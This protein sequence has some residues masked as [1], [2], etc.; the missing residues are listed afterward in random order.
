MTAVTK[1][2]NDTLVEGLLHERSGISD[3]EIDQLVLGELTAVERADVERRGATDP[4]FAGRVA[5]TR[6]AF[7]EDATVSGVPIL[8]NILDAVARDG[9]DP[10]ASEALR[11]GLVTQA[12]RATA[13]PARR[14][15]WQ[16]WGFGALLGAAATAAVAILVMP[17]APVVEP[18]LRA[19]G[20]ATLA[21]VKATPTGP[22]MV[23]SG[24]ALRPG[25]TIQFQA[26]VSAK[27]HVMVVGVESDGT[28]YDA[29]PAQ[30]ARAAAISPTAEPTRLSG[31]L[32]LDDSQGKEW[33]HL[34]WCPQPFGLAD[35]AAGT[36]VGRL[37]LPEGCASDELGLV[38]SAAP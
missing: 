23:M 5:S 37:E 9:A 18:P 12:P 24:D 26:K 6:R 25:D 15:W 38:K 8:Q 33:F 10:Q 16:A 21:V 11:G 28:R 20:S 14:P 35:V 27:G 4:E 2:G 1:D 7:H 19:K 13:K 29:W 36:E 32:R 17:P 22:E 3:L 30:D 34:V 31:G